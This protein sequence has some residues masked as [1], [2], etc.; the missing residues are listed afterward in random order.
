[1]AA[2]VLG[3]RKITA[4]SSILFFAWACSSSAP[5]PTECPK[6]EVADEATG[7]CVECVSD[8]NCAGSTQG[9]RCLPNQT[10]G[11]T[12]AAD[13]A[14]NTSGFACLSTNV[15]GCGTDA[16]CV[17]TTATCDTTTAVCVTE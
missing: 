12:G 1:M 6:Y 7:Q 13:C 8:A 4:L 9:P 14:D 10:C 11:C 15:C 2:R 5:L 17:T 16:D 3:M